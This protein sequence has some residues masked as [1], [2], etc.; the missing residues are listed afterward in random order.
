MSGSRWVIILLALLASACSMRHRVWYG[1]SPDRQHRVEVI[2]QGGH[3]H[4]QID[5]EPPRRY[6]GVVIETIHFSEDSKRLA[7][8][9]EIDSGWVIVVD[10]TRS[11]PWTGIGEVL[12]GP[13]QRLAYV[14]NDSGRWRVVLEGAPSPLYKAVMRGSLTFSPDGR[15]LAFVVAEG[16]GFRVIVDGEPGP[17]YQAI[18]A[19]R[20]D[21]EGKRLAY[22]A[23]RDGQQYLVLG[24]ELL[25][26]FLSL[27][28][29]TLGPDGRLGILIRGEGGWHAMVDGRESEAFDNINAI[30]FS[31]AGR[32]AYAAQR[33]SLW[34]VILEGER[35]PPY[36]SVGELVFARELLAYQAGLGK[37]AFVVV[38]GIRGPS[39]Q[40][41]GRLAISADGAHLAY[42][43]QP[44]EGN[45]SVFHDGV[46]H[47]VSR[48]LDGTLVLSDD[49]RRWACLA[50]N[51]SGK[52]IEVVINGEFRRPFDFEEMT[53]LLVLAPEAPSTRHETML[54]RWVKAELEAS[55]ADPAQTRASEP[56]R[57]P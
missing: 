51:E 4:L 41:V 24:K 47:P 40:R 9:A 54:R 22:V 13:D 35:S 12:F 10:S 31:Q 44:W 55:R 19:L 5:N 32:H 1:H 49:G 38:D 21:P 26:P 57:H 52:R 16:D 56:F 34:L 45:L 43:G 8:A 11:R 14:A 18:G 6:L 7:Y 46:A 39:L 29:F 2:E 3:Q 27:A 15:R 30:H 17:L 36:T 42:L 50:L 37:D 25:G 53:A 23:K 20:F 48:A 33:D 28:D